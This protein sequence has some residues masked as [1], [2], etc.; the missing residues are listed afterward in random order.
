MGAK[1]TSPQH[2]LLRDIARGPQR[3]VSSYKPALRLGHLG[4]A[5]IEH[6]D[7]PY[8]I[9]ITITDTGRAALARTGAP[10]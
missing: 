7:P 2:E 9:K 1:L 6:V 8:G 4:L 3:V 5:A 10:S